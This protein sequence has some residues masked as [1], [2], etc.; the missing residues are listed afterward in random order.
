MTK[1]NSFHSLSAVLL[2]LCLSCGAVPVM[3]Q[4]QAS[5][6]QITGVVTDA[7]GSAITKATVTAT[8]KQ[9]GLTRS[10]PTNESGLYTILLLP[11]AVY[12]V[13]AEASGFAVTS[14]KDVEVT[15]GRSIDV[16][17]TM[18]VSGV[19]EV[20]SVTAGAIQV[21]TTRSESETVLNERAIESLP[22]NGRRFQDFV[23]LTPTAQVDPSR[24]QISL[25]G[26]R[27]INSNVNVDGV[28]YNN[29]FF[30]GIRGGE[31]SNNA[32][33]IPQESIKEFQVVPAGYSAE[34]GRSTG[35]V[36]NAVTKAGTNDWHGSAFYNIRPKEASRT[37]Q[38][39]EAVH[40]DILKRTGKDVEVTPAPTQQQFG[41]SFGGPI[42]KDKIFFFAAYE[43]Q[44]FR[45]NRN[46]FFDPLTLTSPAANTQEA[47]DF[48]TS[49]Q[50]PFTQTNDANAVVGRLDYEINPNHRF[51]VRYGFSR[52]NALNANSVGNALFPTTIS[53]LS[54]NGTEQDYT[55]SITGQFT[56]FFSTSIVNEFRGQWVREERPRPAN[57]LQPLLSTAVGNVGTVSFLGQNYQVD[58]RIQAADSLNWSKSNHTAKFGV[59]Y[60]HVFISQLFGFNQLGTFNVSTS[61]STAT[62]VN[63]ILD[64]L[65][66]TPSIATGTV[67]RFD[68]TAVSFSRQ[69]GNLMASYSTDEL[70]FFAQDS[71]R[72]RPNL[73]LN[74]GLRWEGQ[75]NPSPEANNPTLLAKVQGFRFPSGH[76]ADPTFINDNTKQFGPRF[77]FAWDPWSDGK[78]V[79]RGYGGV[80]YARTPLLLFAGAGNNWRLPAGDL[81]LQLPLQI[82]AGNPN[83][84]QNT[85]YKQLKLIGI[86]LNTFP[87]DNLPDITADKVS[88][89]AAALGLTVDPF[90]GA[91]PI[92]NAKDYKNPT[93]Y[94]TGIGIER[95]VSQALSVGADFT[96]VHTIHL[97]RDRDLNLPLPILRST[98]TDP[99]QRPFYG[100]RAPAAV[101]QCAATPG[102]CIRPIS[103]LGAITI[104]ESTAKSLF[105][106]LTLRTKFQKKWGQLNAFYTLSKN[107]S[108]DDNERD[109]SGFR[110]ENSRDTASE[111]ADSN[112]DRRHQFVAGPLF[113]LPHGVDFGGAIRMFSGL[114]V[115]ASSGITDPNEDRG[116]PDR[117]YLG[118]G[119]PFKRNAFRNLAVRFFDLHGAKTFNIAE[120]KRLIFIVDAFNIFNKKNLQFSGASTTFCAP[121]APA[122][123]ISA[124]CGFLGPTNPNFLQLV[125]QNPTS[126]RKGLILL[127]NNPGPPFQM[128]FGA[129]FQF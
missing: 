59:E 107:I 97:E 34:F 81:S 56:S 69:A 50:E 61:A 125:D 84:S 92:L 14:V 94:Q 85:I 28:D 2:A 126:A 89:I 4:S 78:T 71:W 48:F 91:Q 12:N 10:A 121:V 35:G 120:G 119:A 87:L 57:A 41:G 73:T 117:P 30:G 101:P 82:P 86:D 22:I 26:Q 129:R 7:Q 98:A 72:V 58:R 37:N 109:A 49:L 65:S 15:V 99:A 17:I 123:S 13:T 32:F 110:Y 105:R 5:T 104:R 88:Q 51:N 52:N 21:Q 79:I 55:N 76:T 114:P 116:G 3:A 100:L 47:F 44:R 39:F 68:N 95:Q 66:Y 118:P 83:A 9:T 75:Y 80:Y 54:N 111:Y 102:A 25:A 112:I 11:P 16:N 46:V 38:F 53:A 27:G 24:G 67:N 19:S 29:P 1:R 31:R 115:D 127:N 60:N 63:T 8:N 33:T 113:F 18:G 93:A 103:S 42:K 128:Q 64:I 36:V 124:N 62:N 43:Q 74:Y 108:D 77:G 90:A 106:A 20:V 96:Y 40:T 122:T 6:G 23:T 70:A 45:N